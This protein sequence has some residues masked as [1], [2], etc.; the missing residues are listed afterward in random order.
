MAVKI[1]KT[2]IAS[3][4]TIAKDVRL[5][6]ITLTPPE[7]LDFQAGQF[8]NILVAPSIRR[9]YSIASSPNDNCNIDLI[10]DTVLGG[11]GSQFFANAK[12]GND[13]EF[14]GPMGTFVYIE[15][16]KPAYIFATGT[17][18]VPFISMITYALET[19]HTQRQIK[20]FLGFRYEESIFYKEYFENL[21]AKYPNFEFVLTLSKPTESWQGRTGR[22]SEHYPQVVE[23]NKD[24]DGYI[25]GSRQ[26]ID[27]VVVRLTTAGVASEN[28]HYE[29]YY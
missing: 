14:L 7:V 9:S 23:Q 22:I 3:D 13:I 20:L 18:L 2:K 29:Q 21:Q 25:C 17:G 6:K 1:F 4:E 12:A 27:D 5:L 15:S 16:P 19:L 11:P 24:F 8:I 10:A 26:M 28:I